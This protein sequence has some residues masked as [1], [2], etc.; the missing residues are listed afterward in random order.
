M[1]AVAAAGTGLAILAVRGA[2]QIASA[3]GTSGASTVL[4]ALVFA[5][6]LCI[7]AAILTGA[8]RADRWRLPRATVRPVAVVGALVILLAAAAFGP[9][10][11]SRAWHSFKRTPTVQTGADPTARLSRLSSTRYPVWKSALKAF[12]AH[13]VGGTGAGTFEFTWNEHPS[14]GEFVRDTHNLWPR[15]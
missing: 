7:A 2:P 5:A 13:P 9:R 3:S 14:D 6:A 15:T 10:L 1:A 12:E 11:A 4:A 8:S